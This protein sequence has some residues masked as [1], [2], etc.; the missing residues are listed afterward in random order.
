[1]SLL[2]LIETAFESLTTNKMRT[3]LTMLGVIIGVAAVVTLL[4]LG[5][6]V[7]ASINNQITAMGTN[8]LTISADRRVSGARLTIDDSN[9]IADKVNVPDAVVVLPQL[10]GNATVSAG[11]NKDTPQIQG[12]TPDYF[13]VKDITIQR[14][15]SFMQSDVDQRL[16]VAVIGPTLVQNLFGTQD[17]LNQTI[18]IGTV[19]FRVVGVLQTKGGVGFG[20]SDDSVFVPLTVAMEKL[21]V[22]RSSGLKSL[23][24]ITVQAA[25]PE[26]ANAANDQIAALLRQRHNIIT[27]Q[28]DDFRVFNQASL[29]DT[30]NS[31]VGTLTAFLG[32]IGAISLLVGGIGIMNI[33]LVS[34]TERTRE[35]GVRKAIG[36]QPIAIHLQFLI[37]ALAVTLVAG[38]LGILLSVALVAVINQVQTSMSPQIQLNSVLIAFSVSVLIGVMFGFYPAWRASRLEP[39]EA[40][41]Y[42]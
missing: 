39:V 30:L 16:R 12:V 13:A 25:S 33:M 32:A 40:L 35:I 14:G 10:S 17:A 6:G 5:A 19:P 7:Q 34:V 41:R 36:A 38:I 21:F 15:E 11:I 23:S 26:R 24:S 27:G 2:E 8:Q 31:V 1:M 3:F 20:G 28:A 4:A 42:E 22:T 37:E 18:L 29:V 9:A